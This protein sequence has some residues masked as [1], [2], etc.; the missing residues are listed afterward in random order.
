[1]VV[2]PT[3]LALLADLDLAGVAV[4]IAA[5][6]IARGDRVTEALRELSCDPVLVLRTLAGA[7]VGTAVT[8]RVQKAGWAPC[9]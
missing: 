6:L 7:G 4:L 3:G 2:A 9:V 5:A 1:M 8:V